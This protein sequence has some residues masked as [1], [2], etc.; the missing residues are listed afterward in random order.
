MDNQ[1]TFLPAKK[2]KELAE[3]ISEPFFV[4]DERGIRKSHA[5]VTSAFSFS[6]G[7]RQYFPICRTTPPQ[8]LK[9]LHDLGSGVCCF[10]LAQLRL[11][12]QVGFTGDEIL[13]APTLADAQADE[14]AA[15]LGCVRVICA[16]QTIPD[17]PP[18]HAM[19]VYN[20]GGKLERGGVIY[21]SFSRMKWG[22]EREELTA[23]AEHLLSFGTQSVGIM[24]PACTNELRSGYFAAVAEALF[25]LAAHLREKGISLRSCNLAGGIGIASKPNA[26][27]VDL[28]A[29]AEQVRLLCETFGLTDI[30]LQTV[31][32]R[33]ILAPNALFLTPVAAVLPHERPLIITQASCECLPEAAPLGT[34]HHIWV[35]G[36]TTRA[37]LIVADIAGSQSDLRRLFA[38][39]RI[40][41]QADPGDWLVFHTAG[42]TSPSICVCQKVLYGTDGSIT[43]W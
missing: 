25:S 10:D 14:L 5:C 18:K 28:A 12:V 22:M 23:L 34:Y 32:G 41:P 43:A 26:P 40:L 19:L 9:L 2:L 11:C 37:K 39:K 15:E 33:Y 7:F 29:D 8:L 24:M 6:G 16:R 35:L 36:N 31:L 4:Y 27:S 30:P 42:L 3:S 17:H 13:F 1:A 21:T 20:P 38:E